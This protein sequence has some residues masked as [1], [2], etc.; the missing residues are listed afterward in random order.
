MY[1][2]HLYVQ[3]KAVAFPRLRFEIQKLHI[4]RFLP[5]A[6][7]SGPSTVRVAVLIL[8]E[9]GAV[10]PPSTRLANFGFRFSFG[11]AYRKK[12]LVFPLG[13]IHTV[14]WLTALS[15]YNRIL[16]MPQ[17]FEHGLFL[18]CSLSQNNEVVQ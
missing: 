18:F 14:L 15:S 3:L 2:T 17:V 16:F 9:E 6:K 4:P 5:A 13:R 1:H 10:C 8:G 7:P 12:T 11:V